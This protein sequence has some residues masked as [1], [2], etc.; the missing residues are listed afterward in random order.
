MIPELYEIEEIKKFISN[1]EI[2]PK[3]ITHIEDTK[4]V[5]F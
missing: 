4:Y 5:F 1:K 2:F 3:S